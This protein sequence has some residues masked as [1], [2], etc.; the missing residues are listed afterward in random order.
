MPP[1]GVVLGSLLSRCYATI[2]IITRLPVFV[3]RLCVIVYCIHATTV[4]ETS[5]EMQV[6][7]TV[8]SG[9]VP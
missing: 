8:F 2:L 5:A 9:E 6:A 3:I 1:T 4:T 7:L